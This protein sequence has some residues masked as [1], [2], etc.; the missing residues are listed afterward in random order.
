MTAITQH[1][2]AL[3]WRTDMISSEEL[4]MVRGVEGQNGSAGFGFVFS[5]VVNAVMFDEDDAAMS[6]GAVFKKNGRLD[7]AMFRVCG[8]SQRTTWRR[9]R[10]RRCSCVS[11]L[12]QRNNGAWCACL[13]LLGRSQEEGDGNRLP[14]VPSSYCSM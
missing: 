8:G 11:Q 3:T 5:L 7:E 12:V 4:G 9:W 2:A 13:G 14:S 6:T 1:Y 10:Q